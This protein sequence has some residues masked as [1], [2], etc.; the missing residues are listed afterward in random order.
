MDPGRVAPPEP[1]LSTD[2]SVVIPTFRRPHTLT[3]A[4]LS[5]LA[6]DG[7]TL[8]VVVVDDCPD[9]SAGAAIAAL[10]DPRVSYF[11]NPQPT[12]GKPAVV[13]NLGWPRATG[14]LV[15]FLDDDDIVPP[16]HYRAVLEA[17]AQHPSVG[18]VFGRIE[19]FGDPAQL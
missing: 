15:H 16:G 14:R 1:I 9:G 2:I 17:F 18:V 12:G 3:E 13:R 10:G 7:V 8:E 19:P 5:A 11:R 4:V 6:Q